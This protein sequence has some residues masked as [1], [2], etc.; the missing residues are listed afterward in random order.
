MSP[1][2]LNILLI[3]APVV[4]YLMVIKPLVT[5]EG[6]L[7]SPEMSI[8]VLQ[9]VN[10]D[11]SNALNNISSIQEGLESIYKDYQ[12]V[13]VD[14]LNKN[15]QLFSSELDEAKIRNEVVAIAAKQGIAIDSL[16]VLKDNRG[17]KIADFYSVTFTLRSRYPAFKKMLEEYDKSTRFYHI[18]SLSITRRKVEEGAQSSL[19]DKDMLDIQVKFRVHQAK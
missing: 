18:D 13:N 15:A 8:P 10:S 11:Y 2:L 12:K 1:K 19:I 16:S 4:L 5:G 14:I 17:A 9:R 7:W 6:D 3:I